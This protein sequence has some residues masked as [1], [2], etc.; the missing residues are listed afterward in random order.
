V[1]FFSCGR[2]GY[3][4]SLQLEKNNC[5]RQKIQLTFIAVV[6]L[7]KTQFTGF[8]FEESASKK[9]INAT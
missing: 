7:E 1:G 4:A 8:S 3:I 6:R 2:S 5:C 9:D